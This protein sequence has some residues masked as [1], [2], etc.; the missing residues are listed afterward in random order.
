MWM[1]KEM[2]RNARILLEDMTTMV[3]KDPAKLKEID[4]AGLRAEVRKLA[5]KKRISL[6]QGAH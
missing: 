3:A 4:H 5:R 2:A 1:M 6:P